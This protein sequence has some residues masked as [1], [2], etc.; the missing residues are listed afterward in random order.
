M[1]CRAQSVKTVSTA[2]MTS[3]RIQFFLV[4]ERPSFSES[5]LCGAVGQTR[6]LLAGRHALC[7]S[8]VKFMND[9][10]HIKSGFPVG[11]N[12]MPVV[13]RRGA[14]VISGQGECQVI[15]ILFQQSVEIRG[16]TV[17]I[18]VRCK[19]VT[20]AERRGRFWH[21][22]H[23]APRAGTAD[24]MQISTAFCMDD[25]GQ[26]VYIQVM[27][28]SRA[29]QNLMHIFRCGPSRICLGRWARPRKIDMLYAH[30]LGSVHVD[31][32]GISR[33]EIKTDAVP[34]RLTVV[35]EQ[36]K[37]IFQCDAFGGVSMKTEA[38]EQQPSAG[39]FSVKPEGAMLRSQIMESAG[40]V[41]AGL[42]QTIHRLYEA[43]FTTLV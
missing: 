16:P 25:A 22:L 9:S 36:V 34:I 24:C 5:I 11:R 35:A 27:L 40:S 42:P 21:K 15:V 32:I 2:R 39:Q 41:S 38:Q 13:Y 7:I 8:P 43:H 12:P 19:T 14:S 30:N 29:G 23:Q 1:R 37:T 33:I 17:D 6:S 18:L 4:K 26:Q 20:Y 31:K 3:Q 10:R 28:F